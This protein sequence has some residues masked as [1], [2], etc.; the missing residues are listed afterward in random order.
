MIERDIWLTANAMINQFGEEAETISAT[1]ADGMLNLGDMEGYS[2][3]KR[4]LKA[5]REL[6]S[7]QPDG[8]MN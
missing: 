4:V 5:I 7:A 2:V 6:G 3:W 8:T 1:R